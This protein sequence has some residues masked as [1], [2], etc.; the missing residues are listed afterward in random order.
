MARPTPAAAPA[1]EPPSAESSADALARLYDVDL[2][3]DPG[4]LDLYRA[5]AARMDGPILE[6]AV[7]TGRLAVPLAVDGRRVVGVDA[8]RSMLARAARR[9][10]AASAGDVGSLELVA[11]DL[12]TAV[13]PGDGSFRLGFIALNSLM[14]L[15]SRSAQQEA[16]DAL[17]AR[18][19]PGG[20][21]VV[22]VWL[23][24][25]ED[26]ARFDGRLVLEYVRSDPET[27]H[28]VTKVAS[29]RH[30]AATGTVEL[31]ALYDEGASGSSPV[32]WTRHDRLRLVGADDL[33]A[34][35]AAAGLEVET[36]AGDYELGPF[37][38]G[39]ERAIFVARK[40]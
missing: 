30:D 33:V 35:A 39:S 29:A 13:V 16:I 17:A 34:F 27:G 3:D 40:R 23:P 36:L 28:D 19:M 21:A 32:R 14:L 38:P 20:L 8:D 11:A 24:D 2:L 26:L 15:G 7:G 37:G 1:A 6:L 10:H 4:D 31:T 25:A 22:D 5:L 18:L 12:R 9:A